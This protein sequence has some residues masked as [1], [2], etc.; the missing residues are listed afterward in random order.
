[1][2][3]PVLPERISGTVAWDV[4]DFVFLAILLTGLGLAYELALRVSNR[5]AYRAAA[6][7]AIAAGLLS[8]WIN[9]AVGIVGSEDN[10][11]N[12]IYAAVTAVAVAGAIIARFL[13]LG[14]ARTMVATAVAQVLIFLVALI[15]GLGFTGPITV[16]FAGLWLVSAWLFQ[17]AARERISTVDQAGASPG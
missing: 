10:P 2:V 3:L 17:R 7:I 12:L 6:A 9:L 4:G 8:I 16:F 11:A 1:M 13:P 5:S 14:M 15:A